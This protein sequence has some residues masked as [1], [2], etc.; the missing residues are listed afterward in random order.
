MKLAG[1]ESRNTQ[2]VPD[3]PEEVRLFCVVQNEAL[4]L[5]YFLT[6]YRKLGVD[7]FLIVDN[8]SSD[9]TAALL[10]DQPDIH[11]FHTKASF[12]A[13][14]FGVDWHNQL[15]QA[16]GVGHWCLIADADELLV[17]PDVENLPLPAFCQQ[18]EQKNAEGLQVVLLDMYSDKPMRAL[19]YQPGANLLD[20]CPYFDRHYKF[21]H[22][23]ALPWEPPAFPAEEPIGGPRSRL[24]FPK[25]HGV[26]SWQRLGI[27][28]LFRLLK[29]LADRGLLHSRQLPHPAPQMF[30]VPLVKWRA[31]MRMITNHR[32]S[33]VRLAQTTG[34]LLHFKYLDDF[35]AKT[36]QAIRHGQ[37]FGGSI[38][39]QRY[40]ELLNQNADMTFMYPGS[41]RYGSSEDL[42]RAGI[43]RRGV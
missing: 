1:L 2:P 17:Y 42:V 23:L 32:T 26:D 34:A 21:I 33:P 38:E 5:P 35:A 39:Y 13:A 29:P 15:L 11:V 28:L 18:L 7:R 31:D 41:L 10:Q 43:V 16:F 9:G 40:G 22:R 19:G 8:N 3:R 6:Y 36:Q 24:F 25:Q 30:K 14:H 37:H 20:F 12:A 4:R 27:K